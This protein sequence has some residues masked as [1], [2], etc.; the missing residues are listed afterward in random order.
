M[1]H[2]DMQE[3]LYDYAYGEIDPATKEGV[4]E[5]LASCPVCARELQDLRTTLD[6][7]PRP[8]D[9]PA[10]RLDDAYW[11]SLALGIERELRRK[12][13]PRSKGV[14]DFFRKVASSLVHRPAFT[15]PALG[16]LALLAAAVFVF[17]QMPQPS[18]HISESPTPGI[19]DP[20]GEEATYKRVSDY[21]QKSRVL[22]VGIANEDPAAGETKL[23]AQ[24]VVSRD[25]I[26]EG[27]YL[28]QHDLD[29]RSR[30]LIRDLEKILI[31]L[32]SIEET[33]D[34]PDIE[35]IRGGIRQQN[36]LFKVR[37]AEAALRDTSHKES[38]RV[39]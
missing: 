26:Q 30:K 19:V 28:R 4:D 34:H 12:K 33:F 36:L 2:Q 15:Y 11:K 8:I 35:L 39:F 21:L 22:L 1:T 17:R 9:D 38:Q 37:M 6:I 13:A 23:S 29:G 31:E 32:A 10:D 14:A 7:L 18:E 27:R 20:A 24:R 5:H 25:L 3:L 16:A